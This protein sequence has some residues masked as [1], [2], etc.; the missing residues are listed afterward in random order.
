MLNCSYDLFLLKQLD[1]AA[2]KAF[3]NEVG[4]VDVGGTK[5]SVSFSRGDIATVLN[6][7][8]VVNSELGGVFSVFKV[9]W[10]G[11]SLLESLNEELILSISIETF[12]ASGE[13]EV[14]FIINFAVY[15]VSLKPEFIATKR[16][17][18]AQNKNALLHFLSK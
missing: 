15:D 18:I 9:R 12:C 16:I 17:G 6:P 4:F 13:E 3:A 14:F 1:I 11:L 5:G 10:L 8:G 2:Q 7:V